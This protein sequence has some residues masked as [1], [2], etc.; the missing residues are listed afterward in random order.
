[1]K[2]ERLP[3]SVIPCPEVSCEKVL[4]RRLDCWLMVL[5]IPTCIKVIHPTSY[6]SVHIVLS[7]SSPQ[8]LLWCSFSTFLHFALGVGLH[9]WLKVLR[10]FTCRGGLCFRRMN[11]DIY[12]MVYASEVCAMVR[13]R[14]RGVCAIINTEILNL[15]GAKFPPPTPTLKFNL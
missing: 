4:R 15:G 11:Q 1:M 10:Y 7:E 13:Y 14:H 6:Y 12:M 5:S 9:P 3:N 2:G 8:N